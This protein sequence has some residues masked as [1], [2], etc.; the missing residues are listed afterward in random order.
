MRKLRQWYPNLKYITVPEFQKR[1]AVHYHLLCNIPKIRQ[2]E[3]KKIWPYGFFK[4]KEIHG[5]TH[6]A[7]YLVKYLSKRFDDKRKQGHRLYYASRGLKRPTTLYGPYAEAI[8]NK[9]KKDHSNA[10]QYETNYDTEHNGTVDYK[11]FVK[12]K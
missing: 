6:L 3:M 2:S 5:T 8:T 11:Q 1:G 10:V 12:E 7:F 4:V 9:L